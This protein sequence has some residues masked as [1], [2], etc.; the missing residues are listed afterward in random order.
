MALAWVLRDRRVTSALIGVRSVAQLEEDVAAL[1]HL[2]FSSAELEE[3]DQLAT[4]SGINIWA[5]SS[6][7]G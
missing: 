7:T 3:I 2:E 1:Q 6:E 4:E 5:A